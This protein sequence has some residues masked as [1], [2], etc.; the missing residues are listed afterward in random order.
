MHALTKALPI[1]FLIN[2][3]SACTT[4]DRRSHAYSE[5][6]PV[7]QSTV[8][9]EVYYYPVRGQ[10]IKQQDLDRFECYL[11]A[12]KQSGFDPSRP[13]LTTHQRIDVVPDPAPG[14]DTAAG[15][16]TGAVLGAIIGSP[17]HT[18]EGALIG[19]L[20]GGALGATSDAARQERAEDIQQA[21]EQR[22]TTRQA[23][24]ER[25]ADS[26]RRAMQACL[27]GRGY[28]VR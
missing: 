1:L 23:G 9:T 18:G 21:Y 7:P 27:E 4:A 10:S 22:A 25:Q 12:K 14:Q 13:H 2:T 11:W 15:A 20:A 26:Y 24:L 3:L 16:F 6:E 28:S 5:P 19:A 17:D 8:A